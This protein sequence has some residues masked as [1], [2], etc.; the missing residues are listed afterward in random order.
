MKKAIA[1]VIM[2]CLLA[3]MLGGCMLD[4]NGNMH[5]DCGSCRC[6]GYYDGIYIN[7]SRVWTNKNAV[8]RFNSEVEAC[9]QA[10]AD[11]N[12]EMDIIAEGLIQHGSFHI[13]INKPYTGERFKVF[14]YERDEYM[15]E[16]ELSKK[17]I[18]AI[19][20]LENSGRF[21]SFGVGVG[22][23]GSLSYTAGLY[24]WTPG[25]ATDAHRGTDKTMCNEFC[26]PLENDWCLNM[27]IHE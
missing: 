26:E 27:W 24:A 10:L 5:L 3:A 15:D 13:Q 12:D 6:S 2:L 22:E 9:K 25:Y 8:E 18:A 7:G 23:D 11:Y 16:K 17:T 4:T 14:S 21:T 1:A 20:A 19:E